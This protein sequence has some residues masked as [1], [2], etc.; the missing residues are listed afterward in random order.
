MEWCKAMEQYWISISRRES[1]GVTPD[2]SGLPPL[3]ARWWHHRFTKFLQH[4]NSGVPVQLVNQECLTARQS[5]RDRRT[6]VM[7]REGRIR[8]QSTQTHPS[9]MSMAASEFCRGPQ[10]CIFPSRDHDSFKLFLT[11]S[12]VLR[13]GIT[14]V[15]PKT[16]WIIAS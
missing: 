9:G 15:I 16:I 6:T 14:T 5:L 7:R 3:P 13:L 1:S 2:N 11:N 12:D 4:F 10:I 8:T